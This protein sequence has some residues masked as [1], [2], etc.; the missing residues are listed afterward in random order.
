MNGYCNQPP[1]VHTYELH[2][3]QLIGQAAELERVNKQN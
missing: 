3:C 1:E 2:L